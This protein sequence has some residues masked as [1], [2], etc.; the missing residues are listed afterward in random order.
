MARPKKQ[1]LTQV[2]KDLA[3]IIDRPIDV[4]SSCDDITDVYSPVYNS[5]GCIVN[6][7]KPRD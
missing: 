7:A 2:E 6:W 5:L 4:D 3:E 1:T